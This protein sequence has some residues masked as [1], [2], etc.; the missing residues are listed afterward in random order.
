MVRTARVFLCLRARW[1]RA[2]PF[3]VDRESSAR[4]ARVRS[5]R[6]ARVWWCNAG[7]LQRR[8]RVSWRSQREF[9]G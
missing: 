8:Q 3:G 9:A 6:S 4:P 1:R 2:A 5:Q 7:L